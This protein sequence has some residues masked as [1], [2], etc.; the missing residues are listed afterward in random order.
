MRVRLFISKSA[1]LKA[2]RDR[3]GFLVV[4]PPKA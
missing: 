3:Y 2:G 4:S 1:A